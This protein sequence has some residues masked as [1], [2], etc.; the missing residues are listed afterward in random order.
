[1]ASLVL[2]NSFEDTDLGRAR[3]LAAVGATGYAGWKWLVVREEINDLQ[4]EG[5]AKGF[6]SV[7]NLRLDFGPGGLTIGLA[8]N[9]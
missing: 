5:R 3:I 7:D 2:F 6:L 4:V 8:Y 1:M 9:F